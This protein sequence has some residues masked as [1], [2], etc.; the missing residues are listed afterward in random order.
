[1]EAAIIVRQAFDPGWPARSERFNARPFGAILDRRAALGRFL[2][3]LA[4]EVM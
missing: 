1:M 4:G 2:V 3:A